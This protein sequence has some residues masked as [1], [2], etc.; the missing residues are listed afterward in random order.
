M[1]TIYII[2]NQSGIYYKGVT[3]N[4]EKRLEE[5]NTNKSRFT[6]GKG[7]WVLVYFKNYPLK[8][9]ALIEEK[10]IKRLNHASLERLIS[11]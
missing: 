4:L 7:P 9:E 5:H 11:K 2:E 6:S 10:R 8:S 1:Y 3:E